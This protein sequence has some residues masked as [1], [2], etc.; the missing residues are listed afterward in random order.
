MKNKSLMTLF[1][2]FLSILAEAEMASSM[3]TLD[4]F[5]IEER[6]RLRE[7]DQSA[8]KWN[9]IHKEIEDYK[10]E[11]IR[12]RLNLM[13]N[14]VVHQGLALSK[15]AK[16]RKRTIEGL[17]VIKRH[18]LYAGEQS[19]LLNQ[20]T[21]DLRDSC[22]LLL[23]LIIDEITE[24]NPDD[25]PLLENVYEL[26]II[27]VESIVANFKKFSHDSYTINEIKFSRRKK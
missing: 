5:L 2:D 23:N 13:N 3:N 12:Y 18:A 24:K 17:K 8:A 11:L 4:E 7:S 27:S 9:L 15:L 25:L 1:R 26:K 10:N 16:Y 14:P 6:L 20:I 19:T 22:N 21:E